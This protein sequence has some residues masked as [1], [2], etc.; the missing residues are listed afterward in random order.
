M[1]QKSAYAKKKFFWMLLVK[2]WL[3]S[4]QFARAV[5]VPFVTYSQFHDLSCDFTRARATVA[6]S[7]GRWGL[8]CLQLLYDTGFKRKLAVSL[9]PPQATNTWGVLD[10]L[11]VVANLHLVQFNES[12]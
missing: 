1:Q 12:R 10:I 5:V 8:C 2:T 6:E 7:D 9:F 11:T 4:I 3:A